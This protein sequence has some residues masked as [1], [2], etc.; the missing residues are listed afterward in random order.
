MTRTTLLAALASA[1]ALL[2]AAPAF[3]QEET[4]AA[5][6]A[7]EAAAEAEPTPAM[8]LEQGAPAKARP[9]ARSRRTSRMNADA[10]HC[11][12]LE[13]NSAIIKCAERYL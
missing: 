8:Q 11:L 7:A 6:A 12:D 1:I 13:T 3:A 10:R 2:A 5:R 4:P 9:A